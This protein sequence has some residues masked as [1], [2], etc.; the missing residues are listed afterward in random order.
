MVGKDEVGAAGDDIEGVPQM[1]QGHGGA[2]Q[3]PAGADIAPF[4]G[5]IQAPFQFGQFGPLQQGEIAGIILFV[6]IQIHG[7]AHP[8][9]IQVHLGELAVAFEP[10]DVKVD[11]AQFFI[12]IAFFQQALGQGHHVVHVL[13]GPGVGRGPFQPQGIDILE[14]FIDIA[15]G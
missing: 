8:D 9:L 7:F 3:M 13:R 6:V 1:V 11:G 14:K 2:L 5:V 4:G 15:A 12:G 10:G